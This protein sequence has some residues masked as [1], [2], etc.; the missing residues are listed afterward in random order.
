LLLVIRLKRLLLVI[1]EKRWQKRVSGAL[2]IW[3]AVEMKDKK[4]ICYLL[5]DKDRIFV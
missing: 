1:C 4:V 5:M 2:K 3:N